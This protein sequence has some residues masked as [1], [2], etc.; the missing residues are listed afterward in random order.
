MV[1]APKVERLVPMVDL[2]DWRAMVQI[3]KELERLGVVS[4]LEEM[5]VQPGDTV[6]LGNVELEWF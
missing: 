5:G 2:R 4:V 1:N 6:R 3:W